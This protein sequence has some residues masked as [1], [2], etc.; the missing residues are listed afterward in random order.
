M[1]EQLS[2][3]TLSTLHRMT[4]GRQTKHRVPGIYAGVVR[5]GGF[6]WQE[7]VG[8]ADVSD[9]DTAPGADDQFLVASNS[10]TFTAVLIMQLRDEGRLSLDDTL[11]TF[12][13]EA[14]HRGITIRSMLAHVSGMQREPVG[15]IWETLKSPDRE[16]LVAGFNEA[17]RVHKPHHLWH[18]SN[19][20]FSMLGEVVAR[21]DGREWFESLEARIL[22][23]LEMHRTTLGL[24]G[25]AVRG[26]YVPPHTD[27]PVPE[28]VLDLKAMAACGGLASTAED[29]AKWSAFVASPVSEVLSADTLEE[30]CQ[31]QIM[32]DPQRW[33]SAF[34]LGFM[35]IRSNNRLYVGHTGGMPGHI[36]GLFTDRQS[37]T[38]GL[39]MMNSTSS[40]DAAVFSIE[41]AD[42]VIDNDP[43]DPAPWRPGSDV[44]E[45]LVDLVGVWY[46]EGSPFEFS[47]RQG[48]L[49]AR[50]QALPEHKPSSVFVKVDDDVYR[51]ESGREAGELLRVTR[52]AHGRVQKMN[53]ATYLVT[54]EPNAFGEW[55]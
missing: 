18:Y 3:S 43:A 38:G 37:G 24:S 35:L 32:A 15:D 34:G 25:K 17:E 10:K 23:P 50:A 31:P 21:T 28:V 54:R 51:T 20:M 36:T 44:P 22:D 8:A 55:L 14:A 12:V 40:P 19:L 7:G 42:H 41:L 27:V 6:V 11:D 53:W 16:E 33:Q 30:M 46:S 13:P 4:L 1:S 29:M 49:E 2:E 26:Y 48:R 9:L 5:D 47:V 39:V 45:E 52:D